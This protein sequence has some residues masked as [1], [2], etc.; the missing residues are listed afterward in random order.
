MRL[1]QIFAFL[2]SVLVI[3]YKDATDGIGFSSDEQNAG[4]ASAK[5]VLLLLCYL[6]NG[7]RRFSFT[8]PQFRVELFSTHFHKHKD[9]IHD[10]S[11]D[12]FGKRMATCSSDQSVKVWD[13]NENEEWICTS[14]WKTH[15][16]SVWKVTWAHPE[17]GQV[18]ATCSFDR[19]V[20]VW[21]ESIVENA[22]SQ[23]NH[24]WINKTNL[25]D[26]RTSVK[27]VKFSPKHLGLQLASCS[28]NGV[29]RIYEAPDPMNLTHWSMQHEL[30]CKMSCSCISWNPSTYRYHAPML[31]VGCDDPSN[32]TG[33]KVFI[34]EFS[35]AL[36]DW[37]KIKMIMTI[38]DP[39]NNIA[40]APNM[41][42]KHH[43]LAIASEKLYI[44]N[45]NPRLNGEH[46]QSSS[47][48]SDISLQEV[49]HFA[50]HNSKITRLSWNDFGTILLSTGDDGKVFL[51]MAN[52][53]DIWKRVGTIKNDSLNPFELELVKNVPSS[54]ETSG[55]KSSRISF[56]RFTQT[57][58]P[59]PEKPL[60]PV[61]KGAYY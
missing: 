27:D 45:L 19:T 43:V 15:S 23:L 6:A 51:W 4:D 24:I 44:Y 14:S 53:M 26:S 22:S 28:S 32:S 39:V 35:Y 54:G 5:L 52:Y 36:R 30:L 42:K 18:L 38:T 33:G 56:K 57:R 10:V 3:K 55:Q 40:F 29:V 60:E 21:E 20:A 59:P 41:G 12:F 25:V 31:A 1:F 47:E 2:F 17:F 34:F 9:L 16:A 58:G 48:Q 49:A 8:W 7:F 46:N 13:L 50:D 11:F 37:V 61:Y